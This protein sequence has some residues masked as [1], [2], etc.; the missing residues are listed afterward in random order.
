MESKTD[1]RQVEANGD[2]STVGLQVVGLQVEDHGVGDHSG[3]DHL[4]ADRHRLACAAV[5]VRPVGQRDLVIGGAA[6]LA[7]DPEAL[8]R[9]AVDWSVAH[10]VGLAAPSSAD[11]ESPREFES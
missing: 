6:V 7:S 11:D 10:S 8:S 5:A 1:P 2:R 9:P 3:A 4:S